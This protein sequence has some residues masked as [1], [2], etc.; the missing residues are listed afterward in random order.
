MGA[1]IELENIN[2]AAHFIQDYQAH[3]WSKDY[4]MIYAG[5]PKHELFTSYYNLLTECFTSPLA[6]ISENHNRSFT[7]NS[8]IIFVPLPLIFYGFS[9]LC[10]QIGEVALL[11]EKW[12]VRRVVDQPSGEIAEWWNS[13][14]VNPPGGENAVVRAPWWERRV[15]RSPGILKA[16]K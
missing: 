1:E 12:W 8:L 11:L 6:I 9:M 2:Y 7:S 13:R 16:S 3:W 4:F 5:F 14:V 10:N 15:V